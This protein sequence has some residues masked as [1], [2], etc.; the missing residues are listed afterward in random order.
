MG[1]LFPSRSHHDRASPRFRQPPSHHT[2]RTHPPNP[3]RPDAVRR[4][5]EA[6]AARRPYTGDGVNFVNFRAAI[7]A[8]RSRHQHAVTRHG[9]DVGEV[10]RVMQAPAL[11][12]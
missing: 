8:V 3:T 2:C 9:I 7:A 4:S 11:V 10:E 6:G 1:G 5:V 12:P